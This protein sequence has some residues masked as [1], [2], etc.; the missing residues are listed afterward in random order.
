[1]LKLKKMNKKTKKINNINNETLPVFEALYVI[2][3]FL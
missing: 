3:Q 2:P 1:M